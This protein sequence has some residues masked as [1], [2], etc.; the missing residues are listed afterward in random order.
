MP[1][2]TSMSL[3]DAGSICMPLFSYDIWVVSIRSP[4]LLDSPGWWLRVVP[5]RYS[6]RVT[7]YP[8][9]T[10]IDY[11]VL[12]WDAQAALCLANYVGPDQH[13]QGVLAVVC[14][15]SSLLMLCT[16]K[17]LG[18]Q[19]RWYI[20][21]LRWSGQSCVRLVD[22]RSRDSRQ[23]GDRQK[24]TVVQGVQVCC[25]P[26]SSEQFTTAQLKKTRWLPC[27]QYLNSPRILF[28]NRLSAPHRVHLPVFHSKA[29]HEH[30]VDSVKWFD[31][32]II[33]SKVRTFH[34]MN[35]D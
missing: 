24:R 16:K 23:R 3:S 31:D 29:L 35:D 30:Y 11:S 19:L 5:V 32:G 2:E 4:L 13:T 10:L 7:A 26:G 1:F 15:H 34:W 14:V 12:L 18:Y 28:L 6:F 8:Y 9:S 21:R 33:V 27:Q 20:Y 17:C 22:W 25:T